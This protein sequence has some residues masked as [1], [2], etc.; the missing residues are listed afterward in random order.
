MSGPLSLV[1]AEVSG[2][3]S[4]V[5]E[6]ARRTGL[7]PD[8]VRTML[9]HLIRTGRVT[10]WELPSTCAPTGCSDCSSSGCPFVPLAPR[11]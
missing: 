2:G 3:T 6:L 1:L 8:L 7:A 9:D 11:R 5:P 10:P 4:S